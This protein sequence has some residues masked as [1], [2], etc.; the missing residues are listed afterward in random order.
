MDCSI[1]SC[2]GVNYAV[3]IN[4]ECLFCLPRST[5]ATR[6]EV[7]LM[8]NEGAVHANTSSAKW[9]R[10]TLVNRALAHQVLIPINLRVTLNGVD[11]TG[12]DSMEQLTPAVPSKMRHRVSQGESVCWRGAA[13]LCLNSAALAKRAPHGSQ[14]SSADLILG[15]DGVEELLLL[16]P[17][18][19]S[20]EM[21][22]LCTR[23]M[24]C[25]NPWCKL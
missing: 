12:V 18:C 7:R 23:S 17:A 22:E 25:T 2:V 13:S 5:Q 14:A 24:R 16:G 10:T 20:G 3:V 19:L 15:S 8:V 9:V 11:S 1:L 6:S 21:A 4:S